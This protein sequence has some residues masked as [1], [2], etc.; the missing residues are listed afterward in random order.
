LTLKSADK[1]PMT[2]STISTSTTS[3]FSQNGVDAVAIPRVEWVD[4]P[5]ICRA[6]KIQVNAFLTKA[7]I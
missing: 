1:N 6:S 2:L 3:S 7:D 4:V 5:N